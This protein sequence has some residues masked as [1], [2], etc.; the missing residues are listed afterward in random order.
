LGGVDGASAYTAVPP[1]TGAPDDAPLVVVVVLLLQAP[2]TRASAAAPMA[3]ATAALVNAV[4]TTRA[5]AG[6]SI[7]GGAKG[8]D[9]ERP[10]RAGRAAAMRC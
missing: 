9:A 6:S 5:R 3:A 2:A 8:S 4:R 7:T 10:V 1:L